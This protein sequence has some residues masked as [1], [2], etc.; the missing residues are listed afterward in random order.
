MQWDLLKTFLSRNHTREGQNGSRK[1]SPPVSTYSWDR[2]R[3][4][5]PVQRYSWDWYVKKKKGFPPFGD[6][7]FSSILIKIV[8]GEIEMDLGGT[9]FEISSK[10]RKAFLPN[11][12]VEGSACLRK[13][14]AEHRTGIVTH[15][16]NIKEER[17]GFCQDVD[18]VLNDL[19]IMVR[20]ELL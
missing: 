2:S 4:W 5:M 13:G 18:V 19:A 8:E 12:V 14:K 6:D 3:R 1:D 11:F 20:G 9:S 10:K 15:F 7:F 17:G 16:S